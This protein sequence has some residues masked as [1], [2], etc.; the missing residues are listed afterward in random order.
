LKTAQKGKLRLIFELQPMSFIMEQAGG[1]ATDGIR[2]ILS[3]T[4]ECLDQRSPIYIGSR[5]EVE[6]AREY[7]DGIRG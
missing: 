4:P 3:M 6:T 5:Y 1:M 7:L 2:R